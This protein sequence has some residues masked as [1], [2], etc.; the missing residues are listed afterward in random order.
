MSDEPK[1]TLD[2]ARKIVKRE[3]CAQA[4]HRIERYRANGVNGRAVYD[5]H[6]CE[7]CDVVITFTYPPLEGA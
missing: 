2:V 3:L 1:Y 5:F 7:G 6:S 4:G